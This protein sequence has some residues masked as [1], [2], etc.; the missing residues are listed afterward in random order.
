MILHHRVS[1]AREEKGWGRCFFCQIAPNWPL[2]YSTVPVPWLRD[3]RLCR[4][5]LYSIC[6]N[7]MPRV[8]NRAGKGSSLLQRRFTFPIFLLFFYVLQ[9]LLEVN[10]QTEGHL[11]PVYGLFMTGVGTQKKIYGLLMCLPPFMRWYV[12]TGGTLMFCP[13]SLHPG[14]NSCVHI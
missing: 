14:S 2:P 12:G 13:C 4:L 8:Q 5:L 11:G 7:T 3:A 9:H 6:A 10:I 1:T